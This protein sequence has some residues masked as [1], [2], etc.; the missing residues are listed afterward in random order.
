MTEI[1]NRYDF[2]LLFDVRNGNPN[3]DPDAGNMPRFDSET[4]HGR[5][6]DVCLNRKV[7]DYVARVKRDAEGFAI[8]V[9]DRAVLNLQHK[10]AYDALGL[11]VETKPKKE[12][13]RAVTEF[14]LRHFYDI[15]AFG[16]VM[17]TEVPAG[18]VRGAVRIHM[19][20]SVDPIVPQ[21]ITLTRIAIT[22]ER[23]AERKE[24]EMGSKWIVPY[25][26]YVATGMIDAVTANENG[27]SEEDLEL[28][29][30]A[31]LNMFDN[32]QSSARGRMSTCKLIVFKHDTL[33]GNAHAR[34]L[35]KTVKIVRKNPN[36]PPR[37]YSD[38]D[39]S[40]DSHAMPKGVTLYELD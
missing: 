17:N 28:F 39:V 10:K 16:A 4:G 26:L 11:K 1:K 30:E 29:W 3:G 32:D 38:Y 31:L 27:F 24:R 8:Y 22:N 6:T 19:A 13:I 20:E 2:M 34:D 33:M 7:R 5:V 12:T 37:D 25:G 35:Y 18:I 23:D 15:R 9:S 40:I 21:E 36:K 14:M